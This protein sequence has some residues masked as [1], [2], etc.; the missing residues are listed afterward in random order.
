MLAM[1]VRLEQDRCP[2]VPGR[3]L[4]ILPISTRNMARRQSVIGGE[5]PYPLP[6]YAGPILFKASVHPT[7]G[8]LSCMLFSHSNLVNLC[9]LAWTKAPGDRQH[10]PLAAAWEDQPSLG[11]V[12][13]AESQRRLCMNDWTSVHRINMGVRRARSTA[14]QTIVIC[15][16]NL[17]QS[18]FRPQS[19]S[20]LEPKSLA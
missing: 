10:W 5:V 2:G 1:Q 12:R 4:P 6:L 3:L 19:I 18:R 15:V 13:L 20:S 14:T 9:L 8:V 7:R 11:G 17:P 16:V